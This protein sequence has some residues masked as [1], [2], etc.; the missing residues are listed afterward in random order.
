MTI[1]AF[2]SYGDGFSWQR[3]LRPRKHIVFEET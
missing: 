1:N 2:G 3:P